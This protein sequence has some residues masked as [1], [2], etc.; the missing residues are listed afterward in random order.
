[1]AERNAK[2]GLDGEA[3][4]WYPTASTLGFTGLG[5]LPPQAGKTKPSICGMDVIMQRKQTDR[6]KKLHYKQ[7]GTTLQVV[8]SLEHSCIFRKSQCR[9]FILESV[10]MQHAGDTEV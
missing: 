3:K 9:L 1:M 7:I 4:A 2:Q 10:A 5:S 8:L 6:A